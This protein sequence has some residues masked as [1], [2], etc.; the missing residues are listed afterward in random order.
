MAKSFSNVAYKARYLSLSCAVLTLLAAPQPGLA[1]EQEISTPLEDTSAQPDTIYVT[2]TRREQSIQEAP[3]AVTSLRGDTLDDQQLNS[4]FDLSGLV[5]GLQVGAS[6]ASTRLNIRGIGTNDVTGGADPGVS[7]HL[8]GVFL[9]LTGPAANAFYD[10]DRIEVLRGPQG[11]LF[12]RN[13][14]GGSVNLIPNRPSPTFDASVGVTLG[15]DPTL[16]EVDGFVT[17]ALTDNEVLSGRISFRRGYNDGFTENLADSGPER[18]DDDDSYAIRAQLLFEPSDTFEANLAV[19][20]NKVD[21]AGQAYVLIGGPDFSTIPAEDLGGTRPP[22][23]EGVT[24]ANQGFNR[25]EFLIATLDTTTEFGFGNLKT[26]VSASKSTADIDTDGDG[27]EVD[28]TNTLI[29]IDGEQ[30]FAEAILDIDS[31]SSVNFLVG[32]NAFYQTVDQR[33]TVPI[34]G[35]PA[36]VVLTGEPFETTSYAAFANGEFDVTDSVTLFGGVRYTYDKKTANDS[37]NFVGTLNISESWDQVTYQAGLRIDLSDS[38]NAYAKHGTGFRSGGF[39]LG[40]VSPPVD[41]ETNEATEIGLKGLFFDNTMSLNAAAFHMTYDDL[42]VQ[43][44]TGFSSNFENAAAA[45]ISGAEVEIQ[46]TPTARFQL[47]FNAAYLDATFEEF[48]T[49]DPSRPSLGELDLAGNSLRNAPELS[50]SAG[51]FYDF[52]IGEAGIAT[53]GGRYYWQDEI[54]FN[55]FNVETASQDAVGRADLYLDFVPSNENWRAGVFARNITDERVRSSTLVV[56]TLLGA[57]SLANYEPGRSVGVSFR[58][59]F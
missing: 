25:G 14:T 38:V 18:L 32:A 26:I 28:F 29:E 15:F 11:T 52:P 19:E 44:V 33:T 54:F 43:K 16:Y 41:P 13:A 55:E 4:V 51:A 39:Q 46:W 40:N 23:D 7:F 22:A 6:Y 58:Y 1:Q 27:T 24:F 30:Y 9:G 17:G 47:D 53:L 8:N 37:N 12:G 50:F 20:F 31:F 2:A 45:E 48:V 36:P 34:L 57:A 49:V 35:F 5:P 59:Q 42:Q 21:R 3:L 56:S 10:V